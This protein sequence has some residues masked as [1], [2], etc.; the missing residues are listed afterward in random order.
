[1]PNHN[2][3]I[4]T[5]EEIADLKRGWRC[6]PCWDIE[7]TEGFEAHR[8]E[9]TAYRLQ[10]EAQWKKR[11]EDRYLEVAAKLGCAGNKQLGEYIENLENTLR[12]LSREIENIKYGDE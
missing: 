1:M 6:D 9:L 8:E 3:E 10:I 12:R 7:T 4:R 5:A 11:D 2:Q